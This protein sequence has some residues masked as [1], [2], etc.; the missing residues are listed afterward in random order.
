MTLQKHQ[1][2][3]RKS[4]IQVSSSVHLISECRFRQRLSAKMEVVLQAGLSLQYLLETKQVNGM[5]KNFSIFTESALKKIE[6]CH[7]SLSLYKYI[8]LL[9]FACWL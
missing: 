3:L 8:S 6:P 9:I 1:Y 2:Y 7:P 5:H 4:T